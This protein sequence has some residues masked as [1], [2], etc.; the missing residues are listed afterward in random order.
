MTMIQTVPYDNLPTALKS[1]SRGRASSPEMDAAA[2]LEID[3]AIR[4]P[5]RWNHYSVHRRNAKGEKVIYENAL[6]GGVT[7]VY[8]RAN[9]SG[10]TLKGKCIEVE[11]SITSPSTRMVYVVRQK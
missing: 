1:L 9:R 11:S 2:N 10:I 3:Q 5:C 6:C 4:F 8:R 7:G